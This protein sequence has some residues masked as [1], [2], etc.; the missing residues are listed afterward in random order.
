MLAP[1]VLAPA[2]YAGGVQPVINLPA[3]A[4]G[5]TSGK[6]ALGLRVVDTSDGPVGP[7]PAVLRALGCLVSVVSLD[8]GSCR[9]SSA[10][11]AARSKT[12]SPIRTSFA[13][14]PRDRQ[15]ISPP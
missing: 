13:C 2:A 7:G 10:T 1:T 4:G 5:Q 12:A 8:W 11:V 6:M 15:G 9:R 14:P 3:T